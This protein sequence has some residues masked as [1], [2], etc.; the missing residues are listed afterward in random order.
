[1][2]ASGD[3]RH[4]APRKTPIAV[5]IDYDAADSC[6]PKV[7]ASGRGA[8]AEQILRLAFA[9]GVKVREDADLAELLSAIDVDSEI[10]VEAFIAVAEILAYVY[11][12]NG[13]LE[14]KMVEVAQRG[15]THR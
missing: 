6:A 10:P 11:R 14:A 5:A 15:D 1:M 2:P 13:S 9:R 3:E 4:D 7:V 12:L 8:I